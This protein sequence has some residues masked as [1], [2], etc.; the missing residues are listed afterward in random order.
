MN[1][2]LLEYY[3]KTKGITNNEMANILGINPTTFWKKRT[4]RV[5]FKQSEIEKMIRRLEIKDP[6]AV[7][8]A[9]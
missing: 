6:T 9:G 2:P 1:T 3:M 7:F 8:F 4:G 5:E